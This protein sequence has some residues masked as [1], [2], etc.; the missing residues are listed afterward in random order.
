MVAEVKLA[1]DISSGDYG[2]S[3]TLP[4]A[5]SFAKKNINVHLFLV[6]K[7]TD[8]EPFID[9]DIRARVTVVHAEQVVEMDEEPVKALRFKKKSSMRLAV[10]LVRDKKADICVSSGNTGALMAMS[11]T[12]LKTLEGIS[13]PAIMGMFPSYNGSEV[14]ILDLGANITADSDNLCQF[15][16][17]ASEIVGSMNN[18]KP[19]VGILNVGHESIKGTTTVKNAASALKAKKEINFIGFVEG[20]ELF[21]GKVDIVVCDGFVGNIMLKSCEGIVGLIYKKITDNIKKKPVFSYINKA[22]LKSIVKSSFED[23]STDHK[24]GALFVGLNGLVIKSHG[25]AKQAAFENSIELAYKTVNRLDF[26]NYANKIKAVSIA[27]ETV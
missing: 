27:E 15:A 10:E 21:F 4:A 8:I 18:T 5:I 7:D 24:N 9:D 19:R 11:H 20:D 3:V 12:I 16:Y 23:Y 14:C 2:G 6:G 13:R 17:L 25:G 26:K 22:I 1:I